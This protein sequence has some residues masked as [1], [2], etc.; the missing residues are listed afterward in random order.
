VRRSR[1]F[2]FAEAALRS[3]LHN[4]RRQTRKPPLTRAA[5]AIGR[6]PCHALLRFY[7]IAYEF[8][9]ETLGVEKKPVKC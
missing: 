3:W 5:C 2:P 1:P 6:A 4:D 7:D 9:S 8:E